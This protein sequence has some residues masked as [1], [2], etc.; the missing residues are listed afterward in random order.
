M[1]KFSRF[2]L[3]VLVFLLLLVG[4]DQMFVH[5]PLEVPVAKQLQ[6]FYRDFRSRLFGLVTGEKKPKSIEQAIDQATRQPDRQSLPEGRP[7][8]PAP[9]LPPVPIPDSPPPPGIRYVYADEGG[10]LHFADS[11]A[12]V[13]E[14]FR[15]AAQPLQE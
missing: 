1:K 7:A 5:A 4:L 8:D 13:P 11:L 14:Q 2:L 10:V 12:E 9:A 15:K 3:W 6:V